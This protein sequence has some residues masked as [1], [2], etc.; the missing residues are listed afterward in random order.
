MGILCSF[1]ALSK[2]ELFGII[3]APKSNI[4]RLP[5]V[6]TSRFWFNYRHIANTLSI[7]RTVKR[8]GIPDSN[9][10]L[11]CPAD[12]PRFGPLHGKQP[13]PQTETC[14]LYND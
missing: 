7:Y 9:I 4:V 1:I 6:C 8:L 14:L 12:A 10:I 13:G 3:E 5:Q 11:V 2:F